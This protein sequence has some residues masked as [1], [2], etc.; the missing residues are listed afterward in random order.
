[1][2]RTSSHKAKLFTGS[3][4][5]ER[6]SV[7]QMDALLLYNDWPAKHQGPGDIGILACPCCVLE[8]VHAACVSTILDLNVIQCRRKR[9]AGGTNYS[10]ATGRQANK[11]RR[12]R[13]GSG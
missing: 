9:R 8:R 10:G 12:G 3:E 11:N 7:K 2:V 1:M 6:L 4:D 5:L 13:E